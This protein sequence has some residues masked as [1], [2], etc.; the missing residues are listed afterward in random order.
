MKSGSQTGGPYK[1]TAM[2]IKFSTFLFFL[3]TV[4][5]IGTMFFL[6]SYV[7]ADSSG[8]TISL[9]AN[10]SGNKGSA[11]A[12][13]IVLN[14]TGGSSSEKLDYTKAV[15]S[16]NANDMKMTEIALSP[17]NKLGRVLFQEN[18]EDANSKGKITV[19]VGALTPG[20]GPT[21]DKQLVLGTVQFEG[22]TSN[23][24]FD[25]SLS[26]V[27][28]NSSKVIPLTSTPVNSGG[29]FFS[30]FISFIRRFLGLK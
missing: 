16:F 12:Y 1:K 17:S 15:V 25:T 20:G 27:V 26:Q 4:I 18:S 11:K 30:S 22:N 10:P 29:G 6:R 13:D 24:S 23:A 9:E 14:F 2:K 3:L 21:T 7:Y 28:N 19:E 5:G 8:V